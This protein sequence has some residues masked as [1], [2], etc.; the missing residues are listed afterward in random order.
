M[1]EANESTFDDVVLRAEGDVLVD[2]SA[3]WCGPCKILE[4]VLD[5]IAKERA[6]PIVKVDIDA[7][8]ALVTRYG[9]RGAPTLILFRGGQP[10][11][12]QIGATSKQRLIE[13]LTS[14]PRALAPAV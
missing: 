4:P 9:V 6:L 7:S 10:I 14:A 13:W 5:V 3:T 12:K 1:K 8:P 11:Q 2:F